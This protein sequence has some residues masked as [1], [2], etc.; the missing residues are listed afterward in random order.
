MSLAPTA[1]A[2]FLWC[3]YAQAPA[4]QSPEISQHDTPTTFNTKVNLVNVP[5]VVR[6]AKGH[7]IGN[8][9]KEDFQLFDKGKPQVIS[10][11]TV[12]KSD[13]RV[14]P[15]EVA[16]SDPDVEIPPGSPAPPNRFV[17]Y[18]FDDMHTSFGDLAQAREAAVKH[19][20]ASLKVADRAAIYTTS[21]Q[22]ALDFTDD[23]E[24]LRETMNR[25]VP[26]SRSIHTANDCPDLTDYMADLI[27]NR[28]DASAL[29][30]VIADV[31]VCTNSAPA[32]T[33]GMQ[34][35][36]AQLPAAA[37]EAMARGAASRVMSIA[38]ADTQVTLAVMKSAVQRMS[39]MP[40]QRTIVL[41]SSGFIVTTNHRPDESEV[42]DKAIRA[43]VMISTIDARG[44]Y[45]IVPGGDASDGARSHLNSAIKARYQLEGA[46]AQAEVLGEFADGT[47]GTFF[48][49]NN[50]LREG[51]RRTGATP[52]FVYVLGFS[53]QNLKFDGS[54]HGLKVTARDTKDVTL[55]ARRGYYAPK[56][57]NDPAEDA[58][59]EIRVALFS[60][61]EM[62]DI[63]VDVQTQFFKSTEKNARLS[64]LAHVDLKHLRFKKVEGR[65]RNTLS[66]VS[67]VFNRNGVLVGSI[68]KDVE[69]RLRD[70]TFAARIAAG[71][72]MK[73]SFD[74]APG[75]YIIRLVV[76]D[77]EGKTMAARNR[78]VEIP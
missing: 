47:G 48:H 24:M 57:A 21:G 50:D 67:A 38:E 12:E 1:A 15:T 64:V 71:V 70:E 11:F 22:N 23:Q 72:A 54:F 8:L 4:D 13:G 68:Q 76:R 32:P 37:A 51:F 34:L 46:Q 65:S 55:Q 9:Q 77:T 7:A 63:P 49:N 26:R 33:A 3:L 44:L 66:I 45:T 42:I 25:I 59:E 35:A 41:V 74:V 43:N 58:K 2:V 52:E 27:Q 20:A 36:P 19:L 30:A 14:V 40:G 18:L 10:R 73:T 29:N 16:A 17:A 78:V 6:D 31:I 69:M 53:P 61:E 75:S 56:H 62:S 60:R 5:V 39:A 28:N